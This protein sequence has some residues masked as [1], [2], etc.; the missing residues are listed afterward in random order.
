MCAQFHYAYG[1]SPCANFS[2]S[3]HVRILWYYYGDSPYAYGDQ[4]LTCQRSFLESRVES[5]FSHASEFCE[6]TTCTRH[7]QNMKSLYADGDQDHSPYA[8]GDWFWSLYAY[9]IRGSHVDRR[10]PRMHMGIAW[11]VIPVCIRGFV[12]SPCS[13]GDISV[14]NRMHN[15]GN[16]SIWEIKS[17][18]PICVISHTG[19]AVCISGSVTANIGWYVVSEKW[20]HFWELP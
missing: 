3:P 15:M 7:I 12:R 16:I 11:H 10:D 2:G 1:D 14:T 8:Y 13:Y 9:G 4:F 20:N 6:C 17:C 18:I 19:I 5:E